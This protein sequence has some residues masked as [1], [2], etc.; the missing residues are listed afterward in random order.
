[1]SIPM[2]FSEPMDSPYYKPASIISASL[3]LTCCCNLFKLFMRF[4]FLDPISKEEIWI[5]AKGELSKEFTTVTWQMD[6]QR[7]VVS[8][9]GD[10]VFEK[11]GGL[12]RLS[13]YPWDWCRSWKCHRCK[14]GADLMKQSS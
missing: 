7:T 13:V 11:Q 14:V 10:V 1:M 9:D 12:W 6:E 3:M 2:L 8:V 4:S 5:D